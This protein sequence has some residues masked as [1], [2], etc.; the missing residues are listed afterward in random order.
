LPKVKVLTDSRRK[1]IAVRW[2]QHKQD[3]DFFEKGFQAVAESPFLQGQNDR[4]WKADF[5]WLMDNDT[6]LVKVIEG[7]YS[8]KQHSSM[9]GVR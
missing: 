6:N 1:K 9:A 3:F 8:N 2:E 5:D 7:K 4:G